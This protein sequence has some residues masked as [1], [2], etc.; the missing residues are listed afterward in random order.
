[1]ERESEEAPFDGSGY[2]SIYLSLLNA[3]NVG[4]ERRCRKGEK[5]NPSRRRSMGQRRD[6]LVSM[7]MRK[8]T[9]RGPPSCAS[10]QGTEQVPPPIRWI[11]RRRAGAKPHTTHRLYRNPK[12]ESIAADANNDVE[13]S[14]H[15][16]LRTAETTATQGAKSPAGTEP[17]K[18]HYRYAWLK[19]YK[20][21]R[22]L[23]ESRP[24][25]VLAAVQPPGA[26]D[27][28]TSIAKLYPLYK[29]HSDII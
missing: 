4:P 16:S 6:V 21:P 7:P 10:G 9:S 23:G 26:G 14:D 5:N 2:L 28:M 24:G 11:F 1:M 27:E 13:T 12:K 15:D 29:D 3:K 20:D 17:Y 19:G 8:R 25:A 18:L 22:E